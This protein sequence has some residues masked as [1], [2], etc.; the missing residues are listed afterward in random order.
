MAVGKTSSVNDPLLG[1]YDPYVYKRRWAML[2]LFAVA[3]A[4]CSIM[5]FAFAGIQNYVEDY[6]AP[7]NHGK[8]LSSFAVE[9]LALIYMGIAVPVT[10]LAQWVMHHWG[11][12][13][14]VRANGSIAPSPFLAWHARRSRALSAVRAPSVARGPRGARLANAPRADLFPLSPPPPRSRP[15]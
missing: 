6:Y 5:Q 15:F 11:L 9:T 7:S 14:S 13:V 10:F 2:G 4:Y 8:P 3:S 12:T 1:P